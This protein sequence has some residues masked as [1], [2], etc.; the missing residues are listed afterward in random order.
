MLPTKSLAI[1]ANET[2]VSIGEEVVR[3]LNG[4]VGAVEITVTILSQTPQVSPRSLQALEQNASDTNSSTRTAGNLSITFDVAFAVRTVVETL[5]PKRYVGAAFDTPENQLVYIDRLHSS[6]DPSFSNLLAVSTDLE[7][8]TVVVPPIIQ[9]P[10]GEENGGGGVNAGVIA[11][12]VVG[13]LAAFCLMAVLVYSNRQQRSASE[14]SSGPVAG[15][16]FFSVT[17]DTSAPHGEFDP[18]R[19]QEI[20]LANIDEI[21]TLEDPQFPQDAIPRPV[22]SSIDETTSLAYDYKPASR[23]LNSLEERGSH[24]PS[25][26]D[27]SEEGSN[28]EDEQGELATL[29]ETL[30]YHYINPTLPGPEKSPTYSKQTEEMSFSAFSSRAGE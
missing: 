9:E 14:V 7:N 24:A 26:V 27:F 18:T 19:R 3:V 20:T 17:V 23:A 13:G 11:G 21:S 2:E 15:M 8:T 22:N 16:D 28:I 30:D 4:Q 1:W 29:D 25:Q 5:D 6:G 10:T 12:A